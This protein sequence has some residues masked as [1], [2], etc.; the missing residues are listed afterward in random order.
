MAAGG[1]GAACGG[2]QV[3]VDFSTDRPAPADRPLLRRSVD[4][5]VGRGWGTRGWLGRP[6]ARPGPAPSGPGPLQPPKAAR[7]AP[8]D[9]SSYLLLLQGGCP[10][11]CAPQPTC[12][13]PASTLDPPWRPA[14]FELGASR[15][16]HRLWH[17]H[18]ATDGLLA[19]WLANSELRPFLRSAADWL[20]ADW[21]AN[22][23]L[24]S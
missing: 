23:E 7:P 21:L 5:A 24:S 2:A 12:H 8:S 18:P 11:T 16:A 3:H 14:N 22:S 17:V 4:Q 20:A 19:G 1:W 13:L 9:A 6:A 15:W 10:R